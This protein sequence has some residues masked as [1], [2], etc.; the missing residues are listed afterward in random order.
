MLQIKLDNGEITSDLK[1]INK[2]I[3]TFFSEMYKSKL[4]DVPL[5]EQEISFNDFISNLEIP[6]LTNEEQA[7][8][9]HDLTLEDIKRCYFPLRKIY[10][11]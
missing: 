7:T 1:R 6:Q 10:S 3:E 2:Q 4:A 8:L 9:E 5:S 11:R